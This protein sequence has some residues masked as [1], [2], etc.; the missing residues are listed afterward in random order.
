[1]PRPALWPSG[2]WAR[3]ALLLLLAFTLLRGVLMAITIPHFWGP[4]EDYHFLYAEYITTQHALPSPDKPMYPHEY[5]AAIG[6][7]NYDAYC[8]GLPPDF[9]FSGDPKFAVKYMAR[10]PDEFRQPDEVGR[11]VGVVHPPLYQLAAAGVNAAAGD[12]SLF[13]RVTWVR[14]LTALFGVLAVYGGWLLA[15]Q[16]FRDVRLQLLAAFLFAVQPMV[17]FLAGIVNHD[18]ALIA[19]CTLALAQMAFMLRSPPRA[20][21]G[22][23]LGGVIVLALFVKGSGAALL[24]LAGLTYLL[25]WLAYRADT[26]ELLRSAA[27]SLGL[28]LVLAGW[29]YVRA[30]IV[31][32]SATGSTTA[33]TGGAGPVPDTSLGQLLSWAREWTSLTYRTYWFH[34]ITGAAPGPTF[35]KYVPTYLGA[36]GGLGLACLFW[37]RRRTLTVVETP[38]VRQLLV[39]LATALAFYVPFMVVDVARRA[40]GLSFYVQGGRYLLPA[41]GAVVVLFIAGV[42]ELV[43]REL[44]GLVF[45]LIAVVALVFG[46][47]VYWRFSLTF[48]LGEP[49]LAELARRLTFNRPAFVTEGFVWVLWGLICATLA[50]FAYSVWRSRTDGGRLPNLVSRHALLQPL[51]PAGHTAR[52]PDRP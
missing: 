16:V 42:R 3:R 32:G 45:S 43:R 8:C 30:Q 37:A 26:R 52:S 18:S 34:Y 27:W 28:V 13:T 46:G 23:W 14:F 6:A 24:P 19:F 2:R 38:L 51:H 4:D 39:L 20:A 17:A 10:Q 50:G 22:L 11:G 9:V 25:Q 48:W 47:W 5:P 7:M 1:M 21:Q 12:A 44:R 33:I 31:Y 49:G 36:F 15:A 29:W 41:Y 40:D 35:M